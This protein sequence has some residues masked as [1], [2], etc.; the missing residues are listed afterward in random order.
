MLT[1]LLA[2]RNRE[3]ILKDVL[4]AYC[5]LDVP[6]GGW[7]L[8]VVDNGSSDQ[9]AEVVA[10]FEK[11]LLIRFLSEPRLGKNFALNA[12]LAFL[13]GDLAVFTDDDAFPRADWLVQ[14]R[15]AAD[16]HRD[17][18]MFG[19]VVV[20]RWEQPPP[21]WVEW[22]NQAAVYTVTDPSLKEGP[23]D[24]R[25]I[26]GP[27]MAIRAEIFRSGARFDTKIG[28]SGASYPMGSET[29]MVLRLGRQGHKAWHVQSA[30]V[31]HYIRREQVQQDWVWKRAIR[32]GRGQYRLYRGGAGA[33]TRS[34]FAVAL[35]FLRKMSKQA[36]LMVAGWL[37][38]RKETVFRA[39]W[40]LNCFWGEA[41]EAR[42]L[43]REGRSPIQSTPGEARSS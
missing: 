4:G 28:P 35:Y 5:A 41:M 13:E 16:A 27:N 12:G 29:E 26:Y 23:L 10:S 22:V 3:R 40:R 14:L 31:E 37:C 2:T 8:V 17:C 38:F 15:R 32:F 42:I 9:T 20:P 7:K 6:A 11:R 24:P 25:E 33:E 21:S 43:A 19:G 1:V 18:S 36:A 34:S 30:V 39:H